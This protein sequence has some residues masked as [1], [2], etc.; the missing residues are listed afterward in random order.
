MIFDFLKPKDV[1]KKEAE[2]N[3]VGEELFKQISAARDILNDDNF[4]ERINSM[5]A[6]GYMGG[7]IAPKLAYL[8]E[9]K[10]LKRKYL[11]TIISGIFP[12]SGVNL[13]D[14]K[15][16]AYKLGKSLIEN[17]NSNLK[18]EHLDKLAEDIKNYELGFDSGKN[19]IFELEA[20]VNYIPHLLLEYL[21][22]GKIS[23]LP[24]KRNI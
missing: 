1:L 7:F 23:Q 22:A 20:D 13:L 14:A 11:E 18:P 10:K 16:E 9:K 2:V 19:E 8:F 24:E 3:K 21:R 15:M 12:S 4:N 6:G 17:Q 5:F